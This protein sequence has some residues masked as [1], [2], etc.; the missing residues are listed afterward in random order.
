MFFLID[1][2]WVYTGSQLEVRNLTLNSILVNEADIFYFRSYLESTGQRDADLVTQWQLIAGTLLKLEEL[3]AKNVDTKLS[4]S[5]M[6]K[7][8]THRPDRALA[9]NNGNNSSFS[10]SSRSPFTAFKGIGGSSGN[11][12]TNGNT[13]NSIPNRTLN[14]AIEDVSWS[15]GCLLNAAKQVCGFIFNSFF[16]FYNYL[17]H[18]MYG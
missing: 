17:T 13:N 3:K 9:R 8:F 16:M 10:S 11:G 6:S 18:Q 2:L 12:N 4:P 7:S 1:L 15:L 14:M 5:L